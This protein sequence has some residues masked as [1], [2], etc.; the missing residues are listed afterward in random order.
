MLLFK[1][2]IFPHSTKMPMGQLPALY[3]ENALTS[4]EAVPERINYPAISP[5]TDK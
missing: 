4:R 1:I 5:M 3:L 2:N